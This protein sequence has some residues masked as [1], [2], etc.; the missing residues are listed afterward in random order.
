MY[1]TYYSELS[2]TVN[3]YIQLEEPDKRETWKN[4]GKGF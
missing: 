2:S 4:F 1:T 3:K